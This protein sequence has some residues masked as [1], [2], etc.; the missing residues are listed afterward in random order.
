MSIENDL[1]RLVHDVEP[2]EALRNRLRLR[3]QAKIDPLTLRN[4]IADVAPSASFAL[5]AKQRILRALQPITAERLEHAAESIRIDRGAFAR[6]KTSVLGRLQPASEPLTHIWFKWGA[7]FAVFV[8]AIRMMP[9]FLLASPTSADVGVQVIPTGSVSMLLE[10]GWTYI[11]RPHIIRQQTL[12]RTDVGARATIIFGDEGVLR[13]AENTIV[14]VH[15]VTKMS[16]DSSV[17]VSLVNGHVWALGLFVPPKPGMSI[18]TSGGAVTVTAGSIDIID[19]GLQASATV[20]DRGA[21]AHNGNATA[22]L[23]AGET[24]ALRSVG[25]L[26][27]RPVARTV[28]ADP[29]VMENLAS[30]SVHRE[31]IARL[32]EQR[33]NEAAS[34]LPTS[35]FYPAKRFA[36]E[37]D[38]FFTFTNTGRT[39]KRLDQAH[40]RL[41][42]AL[43]LLK[44]GETQEV[45]S[46]LDAYRSTIVSL[47][48]GTGDTLVRHLIQEQIADASAIIGSKG[49][50]SAS[51][52]LALL[53]R[54][55]ADIGDAIPDA[56]L[57][58]SD[59]EGYI[60][61][62]RLI[63]VNAAFGRSSNVSAALQSYRDIQP[64]LKGFL[65][66]SSNAHPLLKKEAVS[67]L[68]KTASL[69][70]SKTDGETKIAQALVTDIAQFL[71]PAP[72][73]LVVSE[74]A[75]NAR[76]H[77]MYD[78]IFVFRHPRSRYNQL[79]AE[80]VNLER[81]P[82]RG[83]LLRRLKSALPEGLGDYVNTEIKKLGDELKG[84]I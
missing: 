17:T 50:A 31:D 67:L 13:L 22:L 76:V 30:D 14:S 34:I 38:V 59:V 4:I 74:D 39:K 64:Y 53:N 42:E 47:A 81:D 9:V 71:P 73:D 79:L 5:R 80:M 62:N 32:L 23:I 70:K 58:Q 66:D 43:A 75:L 55:I 21:T 83:T 51:G 20:F 68:A 2:D 40:V 3:V 15:G 48:S 54:A 61:V 65:A 26:V 10:Q 52:S 35:I 18:I 36:E 27:V 11:D 49:D 19:D 44:A 8:I 33:R 7:A 12:I 78:R 28:S 72:D 16:T 37:V 1:H 25:A 45:T 46:S 60:I 6:M 77:D 84:S 24:L 29:W 82:N 63:S 57:Q 41:S 56:D 69:A